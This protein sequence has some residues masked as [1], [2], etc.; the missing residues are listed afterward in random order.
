MRSIIIDCDPGQ[1]DAIALLLAMSSPD[2]LKILGITAVAGNVPLELTERNAR[3]M[4]DIAGRT[5][6][7][8]FAGCAQ[9]LRRKLRTAENVHGRTGIDGADI[10]EPKQLL[11]AQH[12]VDFI[13]DAL[14][15]AEDDS[16]TLVPTG[17]LTNIAM[18]IE[19]KPSILRK[20]N[21]IVLMGGAMREGGNSTPSAEFNILVD[22]QAADI[23]FCCGRPTTVM[24]LDVTHQVLATP[25]RRDRIRRIDNNAG[26]ATAG[27]LDFFNRHD[28]AKY[29]S[30]GAP[31]HDPCTVA[32]LLKPELFEGKH[33]NLAVE[34][35]SELTM[36]HTAV[37]F[38]H[39]TD[40]PRNVL[41]MHAVD[42]DGFYALLI[43]RLSRYENA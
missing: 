40:R 4:C 29:G 34:T 12:G 9:P 19:K 17:P 31:L 20:I 6:I 10:V 2:E 7:P 33:C 16:I 13:V 39:V 25:E 26:R 38:W 24:G 8:V 27:M 15:A 22:P 28:T 42:A 18:A 30:P 35:E 36:G 23:V 21:E 11:E 43:D 37:D 5:D 41:W 1:D 32:Y 14:L 3:L